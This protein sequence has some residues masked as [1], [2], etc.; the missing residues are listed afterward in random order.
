MRVLLRENI[1]FDLPRLMHIL[2]SLLRHRAQSQFE[3]EVLTA[4]ANLIRDIIFVG[5]S[6]FEEEMQRH[7]N[8]LEA[9]RLQ[10]RNLELLQELDHLRRS[11][12]RLQRAPPKITKPAQLNRKSTLAASA[13]PDRK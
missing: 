5:Q 1:E 7:Q 11:I 4:N 12:L 6:Y 2:E 10:E 9:V 3:N 8:D 13:C